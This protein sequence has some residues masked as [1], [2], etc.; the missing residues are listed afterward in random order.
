[1][2]EPDY[3]ALAAQ[4][5]GKTVD[6][7][8]IAKK[9]GG[10]DIEPPKRKA[11]MSSITAM[12][13]PVEATTSLASGAAGAT[14]GGLAGGI[15]AAIPGLPEGI[16]AKISGDVTNAMTY[17]PRSAGGEALTDA[18]ATPFEWLARKA[19][20]AGAA[21]TDATGSPLAGAAI[22][23]ALQAAPMALSRLARP[24]AAESAVSIAKRAKAKALG[25]PIDAGI[26]AARD[27]GLAITPSQ[28]KAGAVMQGVEGIAGRSSL[29]KAASKNNSPIINDLIRRDVGLPDDVPLSRDALAKVRE[30]AG[31]AYEVIKDA[32]E[33]TTDAAYKAELQRIT[34]SHDMAAKD[35]AHR[36]KNP[37]EKVFKGLNKDKFDAASAVEEVKLLRSDADKAYRTG[38]PALGRA[39]KKAAGAL[40]D[41]LNRH[42]R[43]Q[44]IGNPA[45]AEAVSNYR[46]ARTTIA[47]TYA[48]D[49][50][51]NDATGNIDAAAYARAL[52]RKEPL[53]GEGRAV[54]EFAAQFPKSAQRMDKIGATGPQWGDLA[55]AAFGKEALMLGARPA[56][57]SAILSGPAQKLLTRPETYA[58]ST[59][60]QAAR[61]AL[62]LQSDQSLNIAEIAAA[63]RTR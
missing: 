30:D 2:T 51:L 63:H 61:M 45:L 19:D 41:M 7:D 62:E 18:I 34:A 17:R 13:G 60:A 16:G 27:A 1:M 58:P 31:K 22:N 55:L 29:E 8:A 5:G 23:T 59:P 46:Q 21:T 11:G 37:F 32:G 52:K 47:K 40:D 33:V 15:A 36:S 24:I 6:Y 53:S 49:A 50:A 48:A 42:L 14:L 35:F 10:Q 4:F 25:A 9:F 3:D 12:V 38:D 43:T 39:Y 28:A 44:A 56:V 54:A 57:R 20:Q 26:A